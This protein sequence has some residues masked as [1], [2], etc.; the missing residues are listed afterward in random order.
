MKYRCHWDHEIAESRVQLLISASKVIVVI[1]R[2]KWPGSQLLNLAS[3]INF[4]LAVVFVDGKGDTGRKLRCAIEIWKE[5]VEGS[6]R[7]S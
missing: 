2:D 6:H 1:S 7:H 4:P 3:L 5:L